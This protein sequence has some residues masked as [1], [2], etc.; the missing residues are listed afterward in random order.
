MNE[1]EW[2]TCTD[3]ERMRRYLMRT[4]GDRK[5]RL[6]ACA[7]CRRIWHLLEDEALRR[8]V[9]VS[10][11]YADGLADHQ[12]LVAAQRATWP[13]IRPGATRTQ[14]NLAASRVA[15]GESLHDAIKLAMLADEVAAERRIPRVE[16]A[17]QTVQ[18]A[19]CAVMRDIFGNPFRPPAFDPA[20]RTA[21]GGAA[22]RLAQVLYDERRFEDMPILADALED[23][24]C[25]DAALLEHCRGGGPHALGCWALDAALGKS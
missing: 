19:H 13:V 3:R 21:N 9:E 4:A 20:W 12:E 5:L 18:A 1:H 11:R 15:R 23:A 7:L 14:A 2:L 16:N 25:T 22:L 8:A 24:G 17:R 6:F 10:E